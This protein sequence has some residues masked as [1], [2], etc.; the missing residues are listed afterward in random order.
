MNSTQITCFLEVAK[1]L[2]F[3][4]AAKALYTTQP[5]IS[6]QIKSLESELKVLLF[7]RDNRNVALTAAGEFLYVHLESISKKMDEVIGVARAIQREEQPAIRILVQRLVDY[8]CL[9]R[10]MKVFSDHYPLVQVDILAHTEHRTRDLLAANEIQLAFGYRYE[11]SQNPR[12]GFLPLDWASYYVL[13]NKEHRLCAYK[14]LTFEDL[15]GEK[16]IIADTELQKNKGLISLKELEQMK[17]TV[18]HQYSSFDSM[19]L[20]VEAGIGFTVLPCG[21]AKRFSGLI[22]I[23]LK[24][25]PLIEQG[26]AWV[27]AEAQEG[28]VIRQFVDT[29]AQCHGIPLK[30][31]SL[32]NHEYMNE[33]MP[34]PPSISAIIRDSTKTACKE[35]KSMLS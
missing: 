15:S 5:V 31:V 22:K 34:Q 20:A 3:V 16:L 26:L 2:S 19:L 25:V 27:C 29:A 30:S 1:S 24:N 32:A 35:S 12:L 23:P 33:P 7:T 9:T 18:C 21:K 8:S 13:V 6:Y 4:R 10:T 14:Y 28:T 11:V 17:I